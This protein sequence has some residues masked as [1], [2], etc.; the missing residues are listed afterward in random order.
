VAETSLPDGLRLL[1]TTF[2]T[3]LA[4]PGEE[5][6]FS[7]ESNITLSADFQGGVKYKI[8]RKSAIFAELRWHY[9]FSDSVDGLKPI[10]SQK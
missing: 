1:E 10:G 8:T 7:N 6:T 4:G 9:Y 2:P 5:P 3:F